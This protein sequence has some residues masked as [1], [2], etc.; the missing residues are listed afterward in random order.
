MMWDFWKG[1]RALRAAFA[2]VLLVTIPAGLFA[3]EYRGISVASEYPAITTASRDLII[4]DLNVANYGVSPQRVDLSLPQRE[5]GWEYAFVGGGGLVEAVFA[6]PDESAS[7]QLWLDPPD[8]VAPGEYRFVVRGQ[9]SQGRYDLPLTVRIG[10][11]LPRRLALRPELPVL[12]GSP[13]ADF[14]FRTNVTNRSAQEA[15]VN[16]RAEAP[17]GF[18]VT[19]KKRFGDQ[20]VTALPLD[21]GADEDIEVEVEP[22]QD[23]AEG[24]YGI[25]VHAESGDAE[26]VAELTVSIQGQP[27]L[28]ITGPDGR[29]SGTAV[30]GRTRALN[31]TVENTGAAEARNI[32]FRGTGPRNW[33]IE[34]EPSELA[35]LAPGDSLEVTASVTPSSQAITGDYAVTVRANGEG[36]RESEEF[37]S[38]VRTSAIWGVVAVVI[39][40]LALVFVVLAMNRYG[41]R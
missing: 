36:I 1:R 37:R 15:V 2:L 39:I 10:D 14:T 27:A 35:S 40:A 23:I 24:D 30:A 32:S 19:F 26:A 18:Q 20:E 29:L 28:S 13:E 17:E 12:T 31:L 9:G 16:L 5:P 8:D 7:A 25:A 6:A 41:R 21:A 38:T 3:Q 4:F 34:F 11:R 33:E 22:P